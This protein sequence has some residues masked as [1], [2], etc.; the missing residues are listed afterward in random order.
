[1]GYR[2]HKIKQGHR[3]NGITKTR[4]IVHTK[5]HTL[6]VNKQMVKSK[7]FIIDYER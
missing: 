6:D 3:R 2:S 1:M 7:S 5:T 4:E